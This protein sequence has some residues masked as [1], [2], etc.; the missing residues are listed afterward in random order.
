EAGIRGEAWA[1]AYL[2]E[3]GYEILY[4][5][6]RYK[7]LEVDIIA[8]D[9]GILVFIEV[10]SRKSNAFGL[11]HEFVDLRKQQNL[12]KAANAFLGS[13]A[14]FGEIRFDIVS[15]FLKSKEIQLIK[16]AFWSD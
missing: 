16:D 2:R 3:Q 6:W 14:Y 15:V 4:Q 13:N 7:H 12:I 11:P 5:N 10:K 1:V 8:K 9:R